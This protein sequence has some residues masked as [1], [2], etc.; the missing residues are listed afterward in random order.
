MNYPYGEPLEN[1]SGLSEFEGRDSVDLLARM[2]YSEARGESWAGKQSVANIA[3]NRK[4]KNLSEFGGDTYEDVLL[5]PN[6]F[7][8]MTTLSAREPDLDSQGWND[9]LYI[10]LNMST[11]DNPIGSCLWFMTN[12]LYNAT[13]IID[14]NTEQYDFGTGPKEVV[15]KYVVGN[16]TFFKVEGY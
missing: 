12:A 4:A 6:A 14:G 15:E 3:K 5:Y 10:A 7:E 11:Q 8:G 9:S 13:V 1:E 2:I 16:Q